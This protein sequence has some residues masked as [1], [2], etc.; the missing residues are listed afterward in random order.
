[1]A[2]LVGPRADL[3]AFEEQP[4]RLAR[5]STDFRIVTERVRSWRA[6]LGNRPKPP[7]TIFEFRWVIDFM[8]APGDEINQ[9]NP[10][11]VPWFISS[12]LP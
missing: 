5:R 2:F 6:E 4:I 8:L 1:M 12:N 3:R 11:V 7:L 9:D 10:F